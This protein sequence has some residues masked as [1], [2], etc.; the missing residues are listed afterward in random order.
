MCPVQHS[1]FHAFIW[2]D[3]VDKES[4][5][6]FPFRSS[7]TEFVLNHPL[8]ERFGFNGS[9]IFSPRQLHG[10]LGGLGI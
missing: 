8:A 3:I 7:G 4:A 2:G 9:V 5:S 10:E 6:T 1:Q